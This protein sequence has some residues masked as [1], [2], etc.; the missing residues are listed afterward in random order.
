MCK[1]NEHTMQDFDEFHGCLGKQLELNVVRNLICS[2]SAL[3]STPD[4]KSDSNYRIR[5][6]QIDQIA[7]VSIPKNSEW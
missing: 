5:M 6:E 3:G 7:R 4:F 2:F 1:V